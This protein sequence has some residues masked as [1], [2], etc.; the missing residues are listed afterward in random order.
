MDVP[1]VLDENRHCPYHCDNLYPRVREGLRGG[2]RASLAAG[3]FDTKW[4]F[5]RVFAA[6]WVT[7]A[8]SGCATK[9]AGP[10]APAEEMPAP[11]VVAAD[12]GYRVARGDELNFRFFHTPE[13]N[14][15][16]TVRPDGRVALPLAGEIEVEGLPMQELT[17]KVERLLSD[18]VRRPQVVINVQGATTR[19][20]FVGGEVA[21]PGM[22]PLVGPLTVLQA[23][24]V[25]EGLK[26][27]AQPRQALVLRRGPKGERVVLPVDLSAVM[28]GQADAPD[29]P[30]QAYD[31]VVVP[32]SG[33]P[34]LNLWIDQYIRRV[35]PFSLGFSYTINKNGVVQCTAGQAPWG[36]MPAPA[37]DCRFAPRRRTLRKSSPRVFRD[38]R[39]IAAAF[40]LGLLLASSFR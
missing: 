39:R 6:L 34:I 7:A 10:P 33:V 20:V 24:L 26:D 31:V 36:P 2:R 29:L 12:A 35:F 32:R 25:A 21:R 1:S 22:Q 4:F 17:A 37:D 28:S 9:S 3:M 11:V 16:A 27:T 30:L 23:V 18:Q 14:T 13:L 5:C 38:R 15:V 19:R 40:L 8:L